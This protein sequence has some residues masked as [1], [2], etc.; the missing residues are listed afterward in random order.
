MPWSRTI[1][2]SFSEQLLLGRKRDSA[3]QTVHCRQ[4]GLL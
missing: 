2:T 1:V 4:D 3:S